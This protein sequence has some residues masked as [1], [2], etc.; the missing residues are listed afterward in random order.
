[1]PCNRTIRARCS[2]VACRDDRLACAYGDEPPSSSSLCQ[3]NGRL[4]PT[5]LA[6]YRQ[7]AQ[8]KLVWLAHQDHFFP[9]SI[10]RLA[11][12][13][14]RLHF[15]RSL[16]LSHI[17]TVLFLY[18]RST[19]RRCLFNQA[20]LGMTC[21]VNPDQILRS[22]A[23]RYLL[24]LGKRLEFFVGTYS[25]TSIWICLSRNMLFKQIFH[26]ISAMPAID[27]ASMSSHSAPDLK[28]TVR[29]NLNLRLR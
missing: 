10:S 5:V 12:F 22:S 17:C 7:Y 8:A 11:A 14:D 23:A 9:L 24:P 19:H 13:A 4:G 25:A 26:L 29:I 18:E 28:K 20:I 2:C 3:V 16:V 1:M 6:Q 15:D 27:A 21:K